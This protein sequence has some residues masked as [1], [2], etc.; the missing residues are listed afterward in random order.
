MA[1]AAFFRRALWKSA[2]PVTAVFTLG[3]FA[4]AQSKSK[5]TPFSLNTTRYNQDEYLGRLRTMF[6]LINPATLF[7]SDAELKRCQKLLESFRDGTISP[8]VTDTELWKA[9][10][11]V[12]AVI[13]PATGEKMFGPGRM[14]GFLLA[15]IPIC[16]G[17]LMHG[18]TSPWAAAFWQWANQSYNVLSNY[19]NRAGRTVDMNELMKSYGLAVGASI[20]ISMGAAHLI[21]TYPSLSRFG[22]FIPYTAVMFAGSFNLGFTRMDEVKNGIRVADEHG[23]VLG[24]SQAAGRLAVTQTILTR[25]IFLPIVPL[26]L[27]P[28]VMNYLKKIPS[29]ARNKPLLVL[30]EL[31]LI[32]LCFG[33]ALP[34]ALA[35]LPQRMAIPV[36]SLEPG[37]QDRYD[38]EGRKIDTVYANKGL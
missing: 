37:F 38:K 26:I 3:S 35:V 9:K 12:D 28:V 7:V 4:E 14:A 27:P 8:T 36:S 22:I 25:C 13:H 17:M 19:T 32:S 1:S 6:E 23:E 10:S 21:K 20:A 31:G 16:A 33:L 15:N 18:P 34:C 11:T 24:V 29:F 5:E 30:S 2:I